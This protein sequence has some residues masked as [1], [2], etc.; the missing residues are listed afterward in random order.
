MKSWYASRPAVLGGLRAAVLALGLAFARPA[1][2]A[3]AEDGFACLHRGDVPCARY[4]ADAL[5]AD[6]SSDPA[7]RLLDA[8][9]CFHEGRYQEALDGLEA[10]VEEG[11]GLP[12]ASEQAEVEAL[13][14]LYRDTVTATK[15]FEERVEGDVVVR[16]APGVDA[17]LVEEAL[18][19]AEAARASAREALGSLPSGR[20]IV[21][22]YPTVDRFILASGLGSDAVETTGVVALSKWSRLLMTS[23]RALAL[24]YAWK[25]T[26]AHEYIH[27]VVTWASDDDAPVWLQEGIARHLDSWWRGEKDHPLSP[28]AQS[29][30]AV[31]L[32]RNDLVTFEEMHP[33]M[34][35][36]PSAERAA[37]AFAQVQMVVRFALSR[38]GADTLVRTLEAVRGG[39][40]A[41]EALATSAGYP[42]FD[43]FETDSLAYLRGL[44][45][46][47]RR[48]ATIRPVVE[49]EGD[50]FTADPLLR[51]RK[52]LAGHARLGDLLRT[53]GRPR[54]AL[55][56][57]GLATPADMPR[58]PVLSSRIALC[59]R[60][61]GEVDEAFRVLEAA[62]RDYPE[63]GPA[64]KQ[65]G[66]LYLARG[67]QALALQG[68]RHAADVNPF[69]P[70]LQGRL[71][72]LYAA[73]GQADLSARH[74]RYRRMLM[75]GGGAG[76]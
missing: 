66:E 55:V 61:L 4:A 41:R 71:S 38:G 51:E 50:E 48:L 34:A 58:S 7:A 57:Y 12:D 52:D 72:M 17:I 56:E 8:Q 15:D 9:T 49:G 29:L 6:D 76:P 59:H 32:A 63:S 67:D 20:V 21:E 75:T 24:G 1:G 69:D 65:L 28:E 37:L 42:G 10:V 22:L 47:Q 30:V 39:T 68:F 46:V 11:G 62:V 14:R 2:A 31:A 26:L 33:S 5:L 64:W 23:P 3:T 36:L 18:E 53:S 60:A 35:F 27:Q 70:E 19:V 54:A 40:D 13:L 74:A 25:D 16:W 45:L 73:R 43:A 44:D